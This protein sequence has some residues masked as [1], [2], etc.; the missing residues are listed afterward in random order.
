MIVRYIYI[1]LVQRERERH[2]DRETDRDRNREK[3]TER[4]RFY[5]IWKGL[6]HKMHPTGWLFYM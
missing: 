2:P 6:E 4:K 5:I 3:T 1:K